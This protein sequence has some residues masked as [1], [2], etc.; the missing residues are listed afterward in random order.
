MNAEEAGL[1]VYHKNIIESAIS[2]KCRGNKIMES[3]AH[4]S[5][6]PSIP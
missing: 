2:F 1:I 4:F 6:G 3:V 5:C